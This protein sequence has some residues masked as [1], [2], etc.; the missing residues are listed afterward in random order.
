MHKSKT[1]F[2]FCAEINVLKIDRGEIQGADA[3][4]EELINYIMINAPFC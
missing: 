4:L 3:G 2:V 1:I